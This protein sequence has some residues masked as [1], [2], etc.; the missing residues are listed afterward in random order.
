MNPLDLFCFFIVTKIYTLHDILQFKNLLVRVLLWTNYVKLCTFFI[1][2]W[3]LFIG[4]PNPFFAWS[5]SQKIATA[6][7]RWNH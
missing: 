3:P 5:V 7:N 1:Y 6:P 2:S 4:T